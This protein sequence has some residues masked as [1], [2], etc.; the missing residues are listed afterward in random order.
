MKKIKI[1]HIIPNFS[2]GGAERVVLGYMKDFMNDKD[3]EMHVLALGINNG[4]IFDKEIEKLKLNITYANIDI[5]HKF[6]SVLKIKAIRK[7]VK[8]LKPDIVHSHLRLLPHV[9]FATFFQKGLKR[10]HTIHAVPEIISAGKIMR[11]DKFCFQKMQ[12][13]PICLNRELAKQAEQLYEIPFCEFLYN[14]IELERYTDFKEKEKLRNQFGVPQDAY[15]V[16]HVGRFVPTKNHDFLIDVFYE[17]KKKKPNSYLLLVGEGPEM[18]KIREKCKKL[19]LEDSVIFAGTCTNVNEVLQIMD[20]YI[21]PSKKEGL[22]ISLI[23]AQAA[24]LRCI[25]SNTVPKE[26]YV[27]PQLIALPLDV[28]PKKWCDTLLE[29]T[30]SEEPRNRIENFSIHKVNEKLK[31]IYMTFYQKG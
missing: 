27:S 21:F 28:S 12:V 16:G 1:L 10:I 17:V 19:K 24:G 5:I 13:L 26:A 6:A 3:I 18:I 31:N 8:E 22:G 11:F 4:S 15:V 7:A 25:T 29:S 20:G 30:M 14:G 2:S 9:T 23:E